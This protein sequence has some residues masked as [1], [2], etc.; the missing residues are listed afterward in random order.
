MWLSAKVHLGSSRKGSRANQVGLAGNEVLPSW[1][2]VEGA[3]YSLQ[4]L[5]KYTVVEGHTIFFFLCS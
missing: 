4:N 5:L 2:A 3:G 1:K